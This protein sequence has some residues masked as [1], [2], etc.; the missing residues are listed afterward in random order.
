MVH[1]YIS[2]EMSHKSHDKAR[3]FILQSTLSLQYVL[4]MECLESNTHQMSNLCL[5]GWQNGNWSITENCFP[6]DIDA[7]ITIFAGTWCSINSAIGFSGNL[8]TL[9]AIPYAAKKRKWD[10]AKNFTQKSYGL[11]LLHH[12][13]GLIYTKYQDQTLFSS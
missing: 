7:S 1:A 6:Q 12:F 10:M 9:L 3:Q 4:N 11:K 5:E 8:L 2:N 13:L